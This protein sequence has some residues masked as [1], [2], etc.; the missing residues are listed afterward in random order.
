MHWWNSSQRKLKTTE[1][2]FILYAGNI[3]PITANNFRNSLRPHR[4]FIFTVWLFRF[5]DELR[6]WTQEL[7]Q[8]AQTAG[9]R[10]NCSSHTDALSKRGLQLQSVCLGPPSGVNPTWNTTSG[11]SHNH[12]PTSKVI[13]P[14]PVDFT[15]YCFVLGHAKSLY[16]EMREACTFSSC[17]IYYLMHISVLLNELLASYLSDTF[18]VC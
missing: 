9:R 7:Q 14:N 4:L 2:K 8:P 1:F 5:R 13:L 15:V 18:T 12:G 6:T 11:S 3:I 10:T 16:N 17:F